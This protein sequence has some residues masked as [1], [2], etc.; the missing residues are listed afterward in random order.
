MAVPC[1][2]QM[3]VVFEVIVGKAL[4]VI[5]AVAVFVQVLMLVPV[6]V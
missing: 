5:V 4:T 1:P 6:T 2:K 3:E